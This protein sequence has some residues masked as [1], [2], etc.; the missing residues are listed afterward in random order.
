MLVNAQ[1][2][3]ELGGTIRIEN[4]LGADVRNLSGLRGAL[5][6]LAPSLS[7]AVPQR[8]PPALALRLNLTDFAV[9]QS[10]DLGPKPVTTG[11]NRGE[12]LGVA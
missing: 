1:P 12:R 4:V 10:L 9:L 5:A 2:V 11:A 3:S 6:R 8:P 7:D